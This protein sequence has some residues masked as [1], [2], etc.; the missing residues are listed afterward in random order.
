MRFLSTFDNRLFF[1]FSY[2]RT[3]NINPNFSPNPKEH[4]KEELK[5]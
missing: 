1:E 4:Q 2:L 3:R 5:L